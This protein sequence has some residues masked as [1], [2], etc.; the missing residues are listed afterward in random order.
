MADTFSHWRRL[1]KILA[2]VS[3]QTSP[4]P[5]NPV[6]ATPTHMLRICVNPLSA[7]VQAMR[8]RI[9]SALSCDM[10]ARVVYV[11]LWG[12]QNCRLLLCHL[13]ARTRHA[14]LARLT[15]TRGRRFL[16]GGINQCTQCVGWRRRDRARFGRRTARV[17]LADFWYFSSRKSTVKEKY[18]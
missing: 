1:A 2:F 17:L 5:P 10:F 16:R 4:R 9:C 12:V 15:R 8:A 11:R 7:G 3:A 14:W 6:S 18:P 13:P